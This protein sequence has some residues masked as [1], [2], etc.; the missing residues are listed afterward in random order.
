MK[1]MTCTFSTVS[2]PVAMGHAVVQPMIIGVGQDRWIRPDAATRMFESK[3]EA[4]AFFANLAGDMWDRLPDGDVRGET[5]QVEL[6]QKTSAVMERIEVAARELSDAC[7]E[8]EGC[9][10]NCCGWGADK[11]QHRLRVLLGL[12]TSA[13]L[14]S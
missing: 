5:R 12:P 2:T 8:H 14:G 1:R 13:R 9:S 4:V 7:L 11:A 10:G 3:E 6:V